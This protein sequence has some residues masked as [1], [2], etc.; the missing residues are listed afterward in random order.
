M[1]SSEKKKIYD[2][3]WSKRNK[4]YHRKYRMKVRNVVIELLGGKC[5][6]CGFSDTRALQIDHI[7][8]GGFKERKELGGGTTINRQ[9]IK[10]FGRGENKFQ[11]L[12]A[13]CNWIKRYENNEVRK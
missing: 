7:N 8:G 13:N 11:L 5:K 4:E 2:R 9:A 6:N 10:S 3:K 1:Y 12:C